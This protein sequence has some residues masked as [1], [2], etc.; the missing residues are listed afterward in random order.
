MEEMMKIALVQQHATADKEDNLKRGLAALEESVA[1]GANLICYAELAFEPFYPRTLPAGNVR[2]LAEPVPGPVTEKFMAK[3]KELGVVVVLN[4]FEL[5]GGK[6]YDCSPVIDADGTLAGKTRMAHIPD[7]EGFHEQHYYTP[8]NLGTPVFDTAAGRIGIA[9]CYDRHYPEYMR[10]L[11]LN[12]A[13]VVVVPQA[14][15]VGEWPDGLYEAEMRVAAFQNG[16]FTAL[17]NR[18]GKEPGIEFAGE[19]FVCGPEGQVIARAGKGTDEILY[20][21]I[22]LKQIP[23]S[24]AEQHFFPDRRP[25]DAGNW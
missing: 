4:L 9:I 16:Y 18:T 19:S 2:K 23:V 6:T 20:A 1:A 13:E 14:G 17:C 22:D 3:A 21:D 24:P 7:Y 5:D 10:A 15:A 11:K 8:G 12:G 25:E